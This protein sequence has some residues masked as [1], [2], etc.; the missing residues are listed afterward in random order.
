MAAMAPAGCNSSH[1]AMAAPTG[2]RQL[3]IGLPGNVNVS[4]NPGQ[5]QL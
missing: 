2:A 4:I 1:Y 5:D 3:K